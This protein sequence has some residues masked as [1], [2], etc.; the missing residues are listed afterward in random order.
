MLMKVSSQQVSAIRILG[1]W[2][3]VKTQ[4]GLTVQSQ[5]MAVHLYIGD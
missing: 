5:K 2:D 3:L 1:V 4:A